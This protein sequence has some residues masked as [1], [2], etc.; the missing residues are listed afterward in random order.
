M[1]TRRRYYIYEERVNHLIYK[2]VFVFKNVSYDCLGIFYG[3]YFSICSPVFWLVGLAFPA[4]TSTISLGHKCQV[5]NWLKAT[6]GSLAK[7]IRKL[8][9]ICCLTAFCFS[10]SWQYTAR[11]L[12]LRRSGRTHSTFLI[13]HWSHTS[14][15]VSIHLTTGWLVLSPVNSS[16]NLMLNYLPTI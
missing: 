1:K 3:T 4:L 2:S 14:T 5:A 15:T 6:N 12:P 7:A 10:L 13:S 16:I 9:L 8:C 11:A